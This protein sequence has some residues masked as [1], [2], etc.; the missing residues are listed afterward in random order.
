MLCFPQNCPYSRIKVPSH[1]SFRV[2]YPE[3]EE[4]K[5]ACHH[6]SFH[7]LNNDLHTIFVSLSKTN[8]NLIMK[9]L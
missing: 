2:I 6:S 9:Y 8:I 3:D 7:K 4:Q 1:G 5:V